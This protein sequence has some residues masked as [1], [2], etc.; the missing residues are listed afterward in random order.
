MRDMAEQ[1]IA[2]LTGKQEPT[3][4]SLMAQGIPGKTATLDVNMYAYRDTQ[5]VPLQA[6]GLMKRTI[7]IFARDLLSGTSRNLK[8]PTT[9]QIAFYN[10]YITLFI[11]FGL[12]PE[13]DFDT[14]PLNAMFLAQA[15]N[16][17]LQASRFVV[18]I[19]QAT[20]L[21]VALAAF[22]NFQMPAVAEGLSGQ[23]GNQPFA[24]NPMAHPQHHRTN[25]E[26]SPPII[27]APVSN[28]VMNVVTDVEAWYND[29][30]AGIEPTTPFDATT[31]PMKIKLQP[32]LS[33]EFFGN[34]G[35]SLM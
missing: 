24:F 26:L 25:L 29:S 20:K 15:I 13:L 32:T 8:L 17:Y 31:D 34:Q 14:N 12:D 9:L 30:Q 1:T 16:I 2:Y 19:N 7:G 33:W 11:N 6:V 5:I 3:V 35:K 27:W 18:Q 4:E 23:S 28:I 21:D 10:Y 22:A